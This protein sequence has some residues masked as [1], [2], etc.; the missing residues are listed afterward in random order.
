[1]VLVDRAARDLE[2]RA[3]SGGSTEP[4]LLRE[5]GAILSIALSEAVGAGMDSKL[6]LHSEFPYRDADSD[7][8][9]RIA[10]HPATMVRPGKMPRHAAETRSHVVIWSSPS[11]RARRSDVRS[12]D[13]PLDAL[14]RKLGQKLRQT[15]RG[16]ATRLLIVRTWM[17]REWARAPQAGVAA[18]RQ[19]LFEV[20]HNVAGLLLVVREPV[21]EFRKHY[22]IVPILPES[23]APEI[24]A[25]VRRLVD[26]EEHFR[27]PMMSSGG[28]QVFGPAPSLVS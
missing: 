24:A 8:F 23:P 6:V 27:V 25:L 9:A 10:A 2:L 22:R 20:H 17:A 19:R 11:E 26:N 18:L 3:N 15:R 14:T 21:S 1:V 28:S 4:I 7:Y 5:G 13:E 16:D 12:L